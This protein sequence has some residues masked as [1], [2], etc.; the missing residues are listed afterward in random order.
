[1]KEM[2]AKELGGTKGLAKRALGAFLEAH[3][4]RQFR[5]PQLD[6]GVWPRQER[7]LRSKELA[8]HAN[9]LAGWLRQAKRP[10]LVVGSQ[11][12][13]NCVDPTPI[14][15]AI[16][17]LGVP[18]WLGGTARGLLGRDGRGVQFRHKRSRALKEA[19]LVIVAGFPFDFRM[20]YGLGFARG[21]KVVSAN[22]SKAALTKNRTPDLA[23]HAHPAEVLVHTAEALG[24][25]GL[26]R[27]AW[28]EAC[29]A[30]ETAREEEIRGK[31]KEGGE[32]VDPLHF[33]L[34]LEERLDEDSVLVVD[35]GD[36]VATGSYIL[37][38]RGP[39]RWLDP[40]VFGTLGVGGGFAVGAAAVRPEA[41]TWIIY[42]DG[43]SA[44]SL[45]EFDTFCRHG[46]SPI[47]VIG[48]DG[49]WAQIARDQV[50]LLGDDVG[51]KLVRNDYHRVAEGY[52]GVGM[53]LTDPKKID[54]TL[55]E[56]KHVA[57]SGRPVCLNVH[58]AKTDFREGSISV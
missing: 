46:M 9:T 28:F 10:V 6:V 27:S 58:I 3:F 39:L 42:G 18:T 8:R 11:T 40:G 23:L 49:S 57:R 19:D 30:R 44:Y 38:P 36:F 48:T 2:F 24:D 53:Q 20:K 5:L 21:A 31:A 50:T 41:E 56:A 29:R 51:T 13:A 33:F 43:S 4:Y 16:A 25:A 45:A 35:G 55:G 22:L 17:R 47:A 26:D 52:G 54:Q 7:G 37:S 14:A 15:D 1:V 34:R 32:L 12:L